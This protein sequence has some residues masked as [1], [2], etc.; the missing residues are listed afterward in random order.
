LDVPQNE[1]RRARALWVA[2]LGFVGLAGVMGLVAY[3][4]H[5]EEGASAPSPVPSGTPKAEVVESAPTGNPAG[6]DWV[7]IPGQSYEMSRTEVTVAQYGAC[8]SARVCEAPTRCDWGEPNW[9]KSGR[10]Q[11]PVNCVSWDMAGTFAKWAG[12]R[13]PTEA[14]WEYA[15]K[16]GQSHEYSGSSNVDEVAWYDKNSEG[17]TH[18]V[19]LKKANGYGLHDMSGNVWEWCEDAAGSSR[20]LRGGSWDS[21]AWVVRVASRSGYAPG[22]RF[23][24]GG[25]GFRLSRSGS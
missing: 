5:R 7:K 16:G 10:E 20:V 18:P 1:A 21:E 8:V 2:V 13:L 24:S 19:E 23:S 9:G 25:L 3:L 17:G 11:H 4:S 6:I 14:E 22:I 12:G 15:A